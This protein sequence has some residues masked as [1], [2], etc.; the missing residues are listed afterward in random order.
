MPEN[1]Q[2]CILSVG[3][4]PPADHDGASFVHATSGGRALELMKLLRFDLVVLS[5]GVND[6]SI[7]LLIRQMRVIAP[8][9]K[10]VLVGP[11]ITDP[12]ELASRCN[13]VLAVI[14]ELSDWSELE[15]LALTVGRRQRMPV[16]AD[17]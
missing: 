4:T 6:V 3:H 9:Q 12:M 2:P 11:G 1:L 14:D 7:P 13:G 15:S 16:A 10:W 5:P 17:A 8:W